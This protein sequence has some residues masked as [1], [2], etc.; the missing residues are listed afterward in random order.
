MSTRTPRWLLT[1]VLTA[2]ALLAVPAIASD[3]APGGSA[4]MPTGDQLMYTTYFYTAGEAIV[5]GYEDNTS[6][7]VVSM[8]SGT[9]VWTGT[10]DAGKTALVP[11]GRGTFG[12]LSDKK[13]GILVG[14]PSSCTVVGYWLRDRDGEHRSNHFYGQLPS[15]PSGATD[16]VVVWG[17]GQNTSFSIRDLTTDQALHTGT[18]TS[19]QRYV[20]DREAMSGLHGHV[21][22]IRSETPDIMVQVY[23]DEGFTVP[24]TSGRGMGREFLTWVGDITNGVNDLNIV[25]YYADANVSVFDLDSEEMLWQGTVPEGGVH[26]LTMANRFVRVVSD[27]QVQVIVAPYAHY[28]ATYAEHHFGMGIEGGPIDTDFMLPTTTELWIFS[29]YGDNAVTVTDIST[30]E[31]VWTGTMTAGSVTG[32]QPGHG[33]YRVKATRGSSVMGGAAS[34]GAEYSP[35]AGM[36]KVDEALLAAV[37]EIR[38]HRVREAEATGVTLTRDQI[39]APLNDAELYQV[40]ES[41]R[42]ATGNKGYSAPEAAERLDSMVTK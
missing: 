13:A 40:T 21:L 30:G 26:T 37:I 33:F 3:P 34:C 18:V 8:E 41:V 16:R 11:T 29:Y 36:F 6:V 5:H 39:N 9:P 35:A 23:Q 32:L 42:A 19:G 24:A 25:S 1:S 2:A 31:Q 27:D 14:T 38:E 20:M 4:A 28:E 15:A 10:V 22:D 17:V 12:F 7:R